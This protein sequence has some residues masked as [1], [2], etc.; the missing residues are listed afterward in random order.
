MRVTSG[1]VTLLLAA[2]ALCAPRPAAAQLVSP[3]K[4]ASAHAELE[5][6]SNCTKCHDLGKK[7]VS[8]TKCLSCHTTLRT[9]IQAREGYHATVTNRT[10][11]SCHR[12]HFGEGYQLVR[13]DTAAFDHKKAGFELRLA[14][15]EAGCRDCHKPA[16]IVEPAVRQY[17]TQH[18]TLQR[19]FLGLG[20]TCESCH[21]TDDPHGDQFR[22]RTCTACHNERT[23][24]EAP[25]FDHDS[26]E[27]P[28]TGRHATVKCEQ[29]HK[30]ETIP[31]APKPARRFNGVRFAQCTN[32]HA[33]PHK[34]AMRQTCESCHS[35]DGWGRLRNR[36]G[37]EATFDHSRTAFRLNGAHGDV[38]CA[39]CHQPAANA[40]P[41][42]RMSLRPGEGRSAYPKPV[43]SACT[44]CHLDA[45]DGTFARSPGGIAC[46]NCHGEAAWLPAGYDLARHNR[47]TFVLT[48]SHVAVPCAS[49][50]PASRPDGPPRFKIGQQTCESCHKK[51]DPHAGQFGDRA[52][53][54]CHAGDA[55]S[56]RIAAFDHAKTRWP[57][58]GA[59]QKVACAQCHTVTTTSGGSPVVRYRP[60]ETTCRACHGASTPRKPL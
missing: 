52:C 53:T 54:S 29:C 50:H 51:D 1:V 17:A 27:Y 44:S 22:P 11:A 32:C 28:L 48:G 43:S 20:T 46:Q 33:D 36:S 16:L 6:M 60:L 56:F 37:F 14:H 15:V 24:D 58:D 45:H 4:L 38:A 41:G 3:G 5:G 23:W 8:E 34:G 26:S 55:S 39:T 9:R 30:V 47:E 12:D 7:G 25:G 59:H 35:T 57:L 13:L 2:A 42:I 10:C 19:T 21:R 40:R 18:R 49:C 31:G